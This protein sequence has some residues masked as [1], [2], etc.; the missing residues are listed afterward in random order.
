MQVRPFFTVT[1]RLRTVLLVANLTIMLLPLG[2][3]AFLRVYEAEMVRQKEAALYSQGSYVASIFREMLPTSIAPGIPVAP[4]WRSPVN[5]SLGY[6]PEIPRLTLKPEW[7][8]DPHVGRFVAGSDA[9]PDAAAAG[10]AILP[11]LL[12]AQTMTLDTLRIVDR[13]G[14][15]VA[16]SFGDEGRLLIMWEEV[17]R[18]LQG[19]YVSLLRRKTPAKR[20]ISPFDILGIGAPMEVTVTLPITDGAATYGAVML[21]GTPPQITEF[22]YGN[23][24]KL[25]TAL[26]ILMVAVT[27]ISVLSSLTISEPLQRIIK[28]TELVALGDPRGTRPIRFPMLAEMNQLSQAIARMATVISERAAYITGFA[29]SVSHEF[30]TPLTSIAGATELLRDQAHEMSEAER[31]RFLDNLHRDAVRLSDL[32]RRLLDFARAEVASPG[33]EL[34]SVDKVVSTVAERF[35]AGGMRLLVDGVPSDAKL[36]MSDELVESLVTNLLDNV[37][38]HCPAGT[39]ARIAVRLRDGELE[40]TVADEGPGVSDANLGKVFQPFF[41]TARKTGG[42]GL[43]LSIV[44]AIAKA[45]K[46]Q[47]T[48]K[49]G[50]SGTTVTLRLPAVT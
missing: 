21:A 45:H 43:G 46:G 17:Q 2:S 3:L 32:V 38:L 36:A 13:H 22:V 16:S 39:P 10:G 11:V 20:T 1:P 23:K 41:T 29:R 49:S 9:D 44:Q 7:T 25:T 40:L 15:V 24:G 4:Q 34:T 5:A 47:A 42:T 28:Q 37:R 14:V 31:R 33:L 6:L 19:E 27:L 26:A 18:S 48:L 30:K 12:R 50:T 35:I 8:R